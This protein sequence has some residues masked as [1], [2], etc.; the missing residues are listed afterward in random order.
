MVLGRPYLVTH[1]NGYDTSAAGYRSIEPRIPGNGSWDGSVL[2]F[3][4]EAE[5]MLTLA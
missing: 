2:P 1:V 3:L 5:V 4:H